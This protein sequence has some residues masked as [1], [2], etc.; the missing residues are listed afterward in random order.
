MGELLKIHLVDAGETFKASPLS[1]N[2]H[3][4]SINII[5]VSPGPDSHFATAGSQGEL[6]IWQIPEGFE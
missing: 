4:G 5:A 3:N 2:A 6:S 1:S